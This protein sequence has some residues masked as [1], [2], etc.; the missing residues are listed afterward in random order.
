MKKLSMTGIVAAAAAGVALLSA[1][2]YADTNAGNS[3]SNRDSSQ[4]GNNFGNVVN[5]NVNGAGATGVNN[6]NGNTVTATNGSDSVVD[7]VH[8]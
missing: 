1:P 2:A 5:A 4:S 3:S 8:D 6:V 7:D